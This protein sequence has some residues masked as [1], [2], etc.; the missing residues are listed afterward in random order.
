MKYDNEEIALL[1]CK[2]IVGTV[3]AEELA[4]L[5][6]W[7]KDS[8]QNEAVFQRLHDTKQLQ[9][10]HHRNRLTDYQRPL[11]D[12]K[13]RLGLG[14]ARVRSLWLRYVAA[15]ACVLLLAGGYMLYQHLN[16]PQVERMT[17][18]TDSNLITPG[19][20][21]ATL[22]LASGETVSLT[23]DGDHPMSLS[24]KGNAL[25]RRQPVS[26]PLEEPL[27]ATLST[28]RGGEFSVVLED[29]TEVWLNA[30]SRLIYPEV[31][32]GTE[33]RVELTGEAYFK[34]T[35]DE[36]KPFVVVS[37]GQEVRVYGTE[38]NVHAYRDEADIYTTL[39][40]GTIALRLTD[41][42]Q[43]RELL[44]TPG[45]QTA[46]NIEHAAFNVRQ[47][48]TE[49]VTSWRSGIFVFEN[50]TLEQIMR[51]L[52]RWYDFDY[53]FKDQQTAQTVFM[54]SIP[55]YSSFDEVCDIFHKLGGIRLT[56]Q[57]RHVVIAASKN[58]K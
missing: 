51:T 32:N 58:E 55:K 49:V 34:V 53:E 43:G 17:A 54:G 42:E 30:D 21:Q 16:H 56:Q 47:V 45:K 18:A 28:P 6:A 14:K 37:G 10:E 26:K 38:F 27:L 39:V 4:V 52:S 3:T 2:H 20:Q 12:M 40:E 33:R 50:Q 36:A 48:D 24:G 29:G 41:D 1:I 5:D 11:D 31:F 19:T 23:S 13:R 46:F 57:G 25:K 8:P 35:H 9:V 44:L 22:T 7:R 15:A